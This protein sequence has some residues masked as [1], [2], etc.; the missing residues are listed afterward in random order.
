M[1]TGVRFIPG[2]AIS[3]LGRLIRIDNINH[4]LENYS[5]LEPMEFI[6]RT[7][8]YIGVTY[9]IHGTENI[10]EDRKVVF[11]SNHPLGGLDGL[12]LA[13]ALN[14]HT[15]SPKLIVND[16]LM[17]LDPLNPMFVPINKHGSQS[18]RYAR[19]IAELYESDDAIITFP[20]GLCSRMI[21]GRIQDPPWK[22]NFV[23]KAQKSDRHILPVF[24]AGFNS[25]RFYRLARLRKSLNIGT[26]L[27]MVLLP[28][29]MFD[30][31]GRHIDIY[32][33]KPIKPN[34]SM[35][36][37]MWTADIRDAAYGLAPTSAAKLPPRRRTVLG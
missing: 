1:P 5:H 6:E 25:R 29:E 16:L 2:F 32:I 28:A 17:N 37:H 36:A 30:Q 18:H 22:R 19:G 34:R 12:I 35:P 7:L 11:A 20:A 33:G 9:K 10:P 13:L 23:V 8:E 24:I 21:D 27:E 14:S 31:K 4:V 3:W 15:P 26:N